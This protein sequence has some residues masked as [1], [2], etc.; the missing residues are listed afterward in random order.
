[1]PITASFRDPDCRQQLVLFISVYLS[2]RG[3]T[4]IIAGAHSSNKKL[5]NSL[6]K[7]S[8]ARG[9]LDIK[10]QRH[11]NDHAARRAKGT[12][13]GSDRSPHCSP[14]VLALESKSR[15]EVWSADLG[16]MPSPGGIRSREVGPLSILE[17]EQHDLPQDNTT[18]RKGGSPK[19]FRVYQSRCRTAKIRQMSP[20]KCKVK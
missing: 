5:R 20:T 4:G 2:P 3:F 15:T 13:S 10:R 14:P 12:A 7:Q 19:E 9:A 6:R 16:H 1:M 11:G 18:Q 17:R 8:R